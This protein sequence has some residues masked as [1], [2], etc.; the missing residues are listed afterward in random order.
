MIRTFAFLLLALSLAGCY[1]FQTL[2]SS[3]RQTKEPP[4]PYGSVAATPLPN[5]PPHPV[6]NQSPLGIVSAD[7]PPPVAPAD[8]AL[9]PPKSTG[10]NP[11][12][13][14]VPAGGSGPF[15]PLPRVGDPQPGRP[16][17][18]AEVK[19]SG[20]PP[21]EAAPPGA[22]K[23]LADLKALVAASNAAWKAVDTYEAVVTRRELNPRGQLNSEVVLFQFRREPVGVY[24][25]NTGESGKGRE[26]I[27]NPSKFDDK[28]YVKLGKGDPFPGAGFVAPPISPDDPK[29]KAKARY[30]VRES[31]FGR[32]VKALT[33]AVAKLDAGKLP[34]DSLTFDGEVKRD[35]F[36]FAVVGVTHK[37]RPGDDPLMLLGGTRR[38]FLD[39]RKESPAYGMPVLVIAID[40]LD[41]E[42]EYYLFEKVKQ[43][44]NLTDASFDP[45]RL[46]K[47]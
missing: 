1:R 36:P 25:L 34:P 7:A 10:P 37:L 23:N 6:G 21:G 16:P 46:G 5:R 35:E 27:Y 15:P 45:A 44:A 3:G 19:D 20:P 11:A 41:R 28:L 9:I 32:T 38:Y 18:P 47:K 22:A 43:P 12:G 13:G 39:M 4:P 29:V 8:P 30:S 40:P 14:V 2:G 31:G 17:S 26:T 42:N 24:S 33:A